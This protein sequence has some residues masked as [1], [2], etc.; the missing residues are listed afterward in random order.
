MSLRNRARQVQRA[1]GMTYQQAMAKLR[2][3]GDAPAKLRKKTGW[4]LSR[5]DLHLL[6]S[7]P[8]EVIER[9]TSP[10]ERVIIELQVLSG[11]R[12]V[13][14]T[15][16]SGRELARAGTP[17][18]LPLFVARTLPRA[19]AHPRRVAIPRSKLLEAMERPGMHVRAVK[20]HALLVVFYDDEATAT[21]VKNLTE[22]AV[23]ELERLFGDEPWPAAPGGGGRS[24]SGGLPAEMFESV[25][26]FRRKKS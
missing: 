20:K 21:L 24:G 10:I 8:I 9:P 13:V 25:E 5:C 6:T 2:A 16:T 11:G 22:R 15:D 4:P 7:H 14:L 23:E 26:I 1:T 12:A 3:L 19:L 17:G 18:E